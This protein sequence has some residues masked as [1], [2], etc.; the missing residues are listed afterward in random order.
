[1]QRLA[2][3]LLASVL[4]SPL[5]ACASRPTTA[6]PPETR[7]EL[8]EEGRIAYLGPITAEANAR[9]RE[10]FEATGG[11]PGTILVSSG[12]GSTRAGL[13]L[14]DWIL[15]HDL[16]VEV[17]AYCLSSCANY[18]FRAGEAKKLNEDSMVLWHGSAWQESFDDLADPGH[19]DFA[20][21]IVETRRREVGFFDRI[22]VDNLITFYGEGF[23]LSEW[24]RRMTGRRTL[25]FDYS[26]QALERMGVSNVVLL[27]GEWNG[28]STGR[29][30]PRGC[31]GCR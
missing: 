4:L 17:G 6:D 26:L 3:A 24:L 5:A 28:G 11:G 27:D 31:G 21:G 14:A 22:G 8:D 20:P 15:D 2:A 10:I 16:D 18:V 7:V 30:T 1:M 19:P 13:D 29:S 23:R 25:G 9:A 12:G